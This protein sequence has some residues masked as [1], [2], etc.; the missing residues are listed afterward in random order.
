MNKKLA[1]VVLA[2][3]MAVGQLGSSGLV[4]TAEESQE[5]SLSVGE[6]NEIPDLELRQNDTISFD[7]PNYG[8]AVSYMYTSSNTKLVKVYADG[9]LELGT[10]VLTG[11]AVITVDTLYNYAKVGTQKVDVSVIKD[12]ENK[13]VIV[14]ENG[15]P[16]EKLERPEVTYKVSMEDEDVATVIQDGLSITIKPAEGG[17]TTMILE[18]YAGDVLFGKGTAKV[19]VEKKKEPV[20]P[21]KDTDKPAPPTDTDEPTTPPQETEEPTAPPQNTEEPTTSPE[22]TQEPVEGLP[23]DVDGNGKV[24]LADAQMAL[25]AALKIAQ[26]SDPN[27]EKLADVDSNGKI[28]LADAQFILKKALKII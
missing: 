21:P 6:F 18:G 14:D 3:A 28:E 5:G 17:E 15:E 13:N 12:A 26:I 19:V 24:E 11:D 25:K 22:P 4:F 8:S 7:I 2:A 10:Q 16:I 23:G 1:T 27:G 20:E 9:Q